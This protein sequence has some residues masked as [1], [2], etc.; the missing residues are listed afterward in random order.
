MS[1]L[2]RID[3]CALSDLF[4]RTL[5]SFL[6][7]LATGAAVYSIYLLLK[8]RGCGKTNVYETSS[9]LNQY[10]CFHFSPK[11]ELDFTNLL[12]ENGLEFPLRCARVCLE[13]CSQ[14][15]RALDLGCGVG[16]SSFELAREFSEVIAVD[17]SQTFV[18]AGSQLAREGEMSYVI[19]EEGV[20]GRNAT[21][22]VD[23]AIDRNRVRFLRADA[24]NLPANIGTFDCI[25]AAN[26]IC[27]YTTVIVLVCSNM[28]LVYV[29]IIG[30]MSRFMRFSKHMCLKLK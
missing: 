30:A 28:G 3:L 5:L 14:R 18:D 22:R 26:L 15:E 4:P 11:Q 16:R 7:G 19:L 9:Q 23:S 10:L 1:S 2:P 21:A 27:R 12:P 13:F 24:S 25:L 20:C 29:V 6:G 8:R 17:Y